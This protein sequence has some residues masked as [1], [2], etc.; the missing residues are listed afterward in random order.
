MARESLFI[1]DLH[2]RKD[3]PEITRRFIRFL[4][5]RA[6]GIDALYM[7][8]D[9][10]DLWIGDDDPTPPNR[11]VI[12]HLR[13]LTGSGVNVFFQQGN[14]DFLIGKRFADETGIQLL[15]DYVVINLYGTSTLLMHGDLLCTDDIAYQ[16]FRKKTHNAQWQEKILSKPLFARLLIA[17]W[18]KFRSSLDK[19]K[20][21]LEIMDVNQRCVYQT[22]QEYSV[23]RLIHGHTHRPDIHKIE[24]E[25]DI[26]F[27]FV[28][29]QWDSEGSVLCWSPEGYQIEAVI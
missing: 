25:G 11:Q 13:R 14:R 24:L 9:I 22:L 16:K 28:L 26:A 29:S 15:E 7:L 20:K 23:T 17:W 6:L 18:Y 1:S 2:L 3:R 5:T 10:F 27:R 8:G 4:D 19:S 12:E 21:S